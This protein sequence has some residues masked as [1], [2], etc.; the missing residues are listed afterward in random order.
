V[1]S[2]PPIPT[3]RRLRPCVDP[4]SATTGCVCGWYCWP[5]SRRP[6]VPS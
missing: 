2:Q 6:P 4:S 5:A 3:D 1:V